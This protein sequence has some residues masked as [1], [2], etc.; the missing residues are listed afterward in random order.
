MRRDSIPNTRCPRCAVEH[1]TALRGPGNDLILNLHL[2][3]GGKPEE[4][5]PSV[6]LY[7]TREEQTKYP[8]LVQLEHDGALDIPPG[9]RDFL[10]TDEF[11]LP[12]DADLLAIYPHAHYLGALLEGYAT[13]PGG[14]R[15]WLIRIPQWDLNWQAVYRYRE[16]VFLP[17]GTVLSMRYHYDNSAA[18]PRNPHSPPQRVRGGNQSTDEMAH[19]WLQL[20]PRGAGDRR[21]V[22]QEALMQRRL[23]KY[24]A[25]F[26]AHFNLG[27]LALSRKEAPAAI[28]H[29]EAALRIQPDEPAALNTLGAALE[30]E[31]KLDQAIAQFRHAL[32]VRPGDPSAEFNL[33]DSLAAGGRFEEA[34]AQFRELLE[35]HP[36]DRAA[37]EHLAQVL[38][39][40]AEAA[41]SAGRLPEAAGYYRELVGLEPS[42]AD[43]RNSFGI[44]LGR[45]GDLPGAIEQFE[46]ALKIDP[47]HAAA[48]RNLELARKKG[49]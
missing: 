11:R 4:V 37:H 31:G 39:N 44:V 34:A 49:Q 8:M 3:P 6:G 20:L 27:A 15:K 41:A 7:F 23:E 1:T 26:T 16:P 46:A 29:L 9:D 2:R 13:L 22:L 36:D 32:R 25:D 35:A 43:L 42:D 30:A 47:A 5:Q 12:L 19:L 24:P 38:L 28:A 33:A 14:T 48:R 10:V 45:S 17:K 21:A 40:L 18:N